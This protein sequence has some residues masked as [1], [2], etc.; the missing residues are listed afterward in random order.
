MALYVKEINTPVGTLTMVAKEHKLIRL[1]FGAWENKQQEII[2]W[3]K[4]YRLPTVFEYRSRP[5]ES[6]EEQLYDYFLGNN[7]PFEIEYE[8]YGTSFQ[9]KVWDMLSKFVPYGETRSYQDLAVAIHQPKAVRAIGGA[10]NKNPL[11][12]IVPCHRIIGKNRRLVGYGGGL[13][14]KNCLLQLEKNQDYT[15]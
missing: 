1:D 12:I 13:D 14:R 15:D 5:F 9:L 6:V 4:R 7:N 2:D 11:S 3:C 8:L 10:V